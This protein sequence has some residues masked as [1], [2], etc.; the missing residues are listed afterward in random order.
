MPVSLLSGVLLKGLN[1]SSLN[2]TALNDIFPGAYVQD[3]K[4]SSTDSTPINHATYVTI[5]CQE[6][7]RLDMGESAVSKKDWSKT[8]NT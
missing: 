8:H 5:Y 7:N 2:V 3:L 1:I 4:G 6:S